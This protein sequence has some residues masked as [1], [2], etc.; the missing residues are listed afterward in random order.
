MDSLKVTPIGKIRHRDGGFFIE[1][2]P[3]YIPALQG[4]E[5]FSHVNVFW[6]FSDFDTMEYRSVLEAP[7]PY[8]NAPPV[9]GVFA[10]RSPLRPNPIALTAS[11]VIRVDA[12]KGVIELTY[13]D[14]NDGTP[15][16]DIKPYTPSFD[17][18][19]NPG[20]PQWCA[21]WPNSLEESGSFPWEREFNF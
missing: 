18:I 13:T 7:Q 11:E 10:T 3:G 19:E 9:M 20:V 1:V 6:W 4:L 15:V 16:I 8:K 2:D 5:G 12:E 14:A 21:H 17:R